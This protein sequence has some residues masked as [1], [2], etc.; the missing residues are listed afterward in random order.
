MEGAGGGLCSR[1]FGVERGGMVP[2]GGWWAGGD[3]RFYKSQ[4]K[5]RDKILSAV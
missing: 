2:M 4:C 1:V 5:S 3:V